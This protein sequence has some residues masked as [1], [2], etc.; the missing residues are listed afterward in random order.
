MFKGLKVSAAEWLRAMFKSFRGNCVQ[1]ENEK[2]EACRNVQDVEN[3]REILIRYL[4]DQ[5]KIYIKN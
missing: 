5:K 2:L 3:Y 1:D 4:T